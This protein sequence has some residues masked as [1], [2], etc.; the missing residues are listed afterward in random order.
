MLRETV[1]VPSWVA[2][3]AYPEVETE[4]E[5]RAELLRVLRRAAEDPRFVAALTEDPER[6]LAG[7]RLTLEERAALLSGDVA[8]I[9]AAVGKLHP[10]ELT[11]LECRLQQ[12]IW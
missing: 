5:P 12:E 4:R 3:L 11:W 8:W 1:D 7:Y 9:S 2:S 6:A 10:E